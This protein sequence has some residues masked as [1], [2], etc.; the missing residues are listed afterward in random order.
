ANVLPV[1]NTRCSFAG[2]CAAWNLSPIPDRT[3]A[4]RRSTGWSKVNT[5]AGSAPLTGAAQYV[6]IALSL[7]SFA[8]WP[9]SATFDVTLTGCTGT[10]LVSKIPV[11]W[12][13]N[14]TAVLFT[15]VLKG[16]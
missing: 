6:L 11:A 16:T 1:E 4:R 14:P 13:H 3:N 7:T 2:R 8:S 15:T 9:G 12:F 10:Y 5:S